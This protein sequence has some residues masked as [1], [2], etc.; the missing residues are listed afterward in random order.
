[1]IVKK[2]SQFCVMSKDKSKNLGCYDS[3]GEAKKRLSEVEYFKKKGK[4][5]FEEYDTVEIE[6]VKEDHEEDEEDMDMKKKKKKKMMMDEHDEMMKKKMSMMKEDVIP[7]KITIKAAADEFKS[8]SSKKGIQVRTS[9]IYG[10][11]F[12]E[13]GSEMIVEGFIATTHKDSVNDIITK[14]TLE[15]WADEINAGIPRVNKASYHHDRSDPRVVGVAIKD[16][17]QVLPFNDGEH[18]LYV[19]RW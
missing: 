11:N 14:E 9:K 7:S 3:E 5:L 1:M 15:K 17:A 8:I 4:E 16:S 18:G 13:E 12:K 2:G 6:E 19:K 10:L